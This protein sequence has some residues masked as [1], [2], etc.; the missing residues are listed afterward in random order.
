MIIYEKAPGV[1]RISDQELR[2]HL[3]KREYARWLRWYRE[4]KGEYEAYLVEQFLA[5]ETNHIRARAN[6]PSSP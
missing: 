1:F 5:G 4:K 3:G 2:S 6:L